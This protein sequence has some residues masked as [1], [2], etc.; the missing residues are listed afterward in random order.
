MVHSLAVA[1]GSHQRARAASPL[2]R[3]GINSGRRGE[4][5]DGARMEEMMRTKRSGLKEERGERGVTKLQ[6]RLQVDGGGGGRANMSGA[7]VA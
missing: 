4:A 6:R 2:S 1:G 5:T 3:G 7:I